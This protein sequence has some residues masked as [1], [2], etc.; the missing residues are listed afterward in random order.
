MITIPLFESKPDSKIL[1]VLKKLK[2]KILDNKSVLG[3][4]E[5]ITERENPDTGKTAK[6]IASEVEA[7]L[8]KLLPEWNV[9]IKEGDYTDTIT[10][11]DKAISDIKKGDEP[12]YRWKK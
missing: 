9:K 3:G 2:L 11:V 10:I 4:M 12:M 7:E 6:V 5:I 1:S 8:E